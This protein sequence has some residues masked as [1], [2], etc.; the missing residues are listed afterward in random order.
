[1]SANWIKPERL[2]GVARPV[3]PDADIG[4]WEQAV[5]QAAPFCLV[6]LATD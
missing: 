6:L 3:P 1:M 5:G 4:S 2:F